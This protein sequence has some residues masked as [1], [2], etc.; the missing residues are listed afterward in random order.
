MADDRSD[1][2]T[3]IGRLELVVVDASGKITAQKPIISSF[4]AQID[5]RDRGRR[6]WVRRSRGP[7]SGKGTER[8]AWRRSARTAR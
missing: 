7:T 4:T 2:P 6:R 3:Q 5:R 8:C 1:Q